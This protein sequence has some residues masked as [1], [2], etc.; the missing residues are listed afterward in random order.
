MSVSFRCPDC[1]STHHS[2]LRAPDGQ[3][4]ATAM[5][6]FGAIEEICPRTHRWVRVG[7]DELSWARD[8]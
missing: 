6:A 7:A 2:R 3:W 5:H 4:L 8:A 1:R